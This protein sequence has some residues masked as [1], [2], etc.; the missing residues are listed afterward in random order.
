MFFEHNIDFVMDLIDKS[1]Q[2]QSFHALKIGI[3][4]KSLVLFSMVT[5]NRCHTKSMEKYCSK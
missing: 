3:Q 1:G 4:F 2:F 5:T